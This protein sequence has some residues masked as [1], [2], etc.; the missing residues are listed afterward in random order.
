MCHYTADDPGASFSFT[1]NEGI[2]SPGAIFRPF[3]VWTRFFIFR[4]HSF[5]LV[6]AVQIH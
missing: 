2:L 5:P 6:F 3:F 4:H 1:D